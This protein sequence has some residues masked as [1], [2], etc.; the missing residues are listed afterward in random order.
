M[1]AVE[2][3]ERVLRKVMLKNI[4]PSALNKN[5]M[6]A[7]S[8]ESIERLAGTLQEQ[9]LIQP[10][11]LRVADEGFEIVAG[12]RRYRAAKLLG[13]E[14]IDAIIG[15]YEDDAAAHVDRVIENLHR[16]NLPPLEEAAGVAILF[17]R[18]FSAEDIARRVGV[19]TSFVY[20]RRKLARLTPRWKKELEK[21]DTAYKQFAEHLTWLEEVASLAPE[22]Q[23]WLLENGELRYANNRERVKS[24][25]QD[26]LM[27]IADAPWD[28][29]AKGFV[30]KSIVE[31]DGCEFRTDTSG[32]FPEFESDDS[33]RCC[34]PD[35]WQRKLN[36]WLMFQVQKL[37][38][39]KSLPVGY[40]AGY[41]FDHKK[42][43]AEFQQLI[44]DLE[45]VDNV[46]CYKDRD[47]AEGRNDFGYYDLRQMCL[48]DLRE[49]GSDEDNVF[50]AI[51]NFWVRGE[52]VSTSEA[53]TPRRVNHDKTHPLRPSIEYLVKLLWSSEDD[54]DKALLPVVSHEHLL[55]LSAMFTPHQDLS[56]GFDHGN[57]PE[58]YRWSLETACEQLWRGI[59]WSIYDNLAYDYSTCRPDTA[60]ELKTLCELLE[61]NSDQLGAVMALVELTSRS[62]EV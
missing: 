6:A 16:E 34:M 8:P 46:N 48:L 57:L 56:D 25:I 44:K 28:D 9:G 24:L 5:R 49:S 54:E 17:E 11:V 32:L 60:E 61:L 45:K 22:S 29:A 12:E 2:E 33:A 37:S 20:S 58:N 27:V 41:W 15:D 10:I 51:S 52:Y 30:G 42:Y 13:W 3:K 36:K 7:L 39:D 43:S 38:K 47:D 62:E 53:S 23:D 4:R 59:C 26:A 18:G 35:C 31:C 55:I 1:S 21:E 50:S 19:S 40:V 14:T